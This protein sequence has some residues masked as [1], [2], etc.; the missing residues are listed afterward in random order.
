MEVLASMELTVSNVFVSMD[1]EASSARKILT[2]VLR[3]HVSTEPLA[4]TTSTLLLVNAEV[5]FLEPIA[6]STMKT[7]LKA[8][9]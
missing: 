6:K 1:L 3:I 9:A 2:N 8:L 7:A 5:A 4:T